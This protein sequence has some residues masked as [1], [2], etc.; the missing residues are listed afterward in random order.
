[1]RRKHRRSSL[2][3]SGQRWR[4]AAPEGPRAR[5]GSF[6][7]TARQ[8]ALTNPNHPLQTNPSCSARGGAWT[9]FTCVLG[10]GSGSAGVACADTFKLFSFRFPKGGRRAFR[11]GNGAGLRRCVRQQETARELVFAVQAG[12]RSAGGTSDLAAPSGERRGPT[13]AGA[14]PVDR[15]SH[16]TES[17]SAWS[18]AS[19]PG[20][21]STQCAQPQPSAAGSL[22]PF[23][24]VLKQSPGVVCCTRLTL[25]VPSA[26]YTQSTIIGRQNNEDFRSLLRVAQF[27]H[28]RCVLA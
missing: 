10:R 9:R 20:C 18:Q 13:D 3:L 23:C 16:T 11:E 2:S 1:M 17:A 27:H 6:S 25:P 26:D 5:S 4:P 14:R 21:H 19:G 24:V 12:E 7:W 22:F 28:F 8:R 15:S